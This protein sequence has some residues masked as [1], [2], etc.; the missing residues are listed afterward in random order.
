MHELYELKDKLM[1]ELEEYSRK[2]LSA[3]SLD[4]IDKLSHTIKNLCKIMEDEEGYSREDGSMRMNGTVY[5][6]GSYRGGSYRGGSYARNRRRDSMGRYMDGGYSRDED[7]IAE[8]RELM[9]DVPE[10][11]KQ[12]FQKLIRKM[13]NM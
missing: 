10:E 2:D 12:D 11:M 5:R 8:M 9:N 7:L 6:G 1:E 4:V 3:G 13:E